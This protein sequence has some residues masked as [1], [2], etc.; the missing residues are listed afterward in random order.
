MVTNS[1]LATDICF[2][3][4]KK[5]MKIKGIISDMDGVIYRGNKLIPEAKNFIECLHKNQLPFFFLTNNSEL[6]ALDLKLKMQA[7]GIE[8][9]TENNF[10]T[11]AMA[12]A[13]FLKNQ[14]PGSK[15]FVIGKGGLINELY[16]A[17]FSLTEHNP[18]YV[19]VGKTNDFNFTMLKKAV[20]LINQ[21][22]KFI[23]T[24]PDV[25]DPIENGVEPACGSILAAIEKAANKAPYIIGKPNALIMTIAT[26]KLNLH[27]EEILMVGDRMDTDIV[28]GLEA[29]MKT[30]LVL[31]GVSQRETLNEFPFQPDFV[32]NNVGEIQTIFNF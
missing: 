17:G 26:Q 6:T 13:I 16:N 28:A 24:N 27:S 23:G 2:S 11:S 4:T 18:D 20:N 10:I 3:Y 21:G 31:T 14:K 5:I 30:C 22:A 8:G 25:I 7:L 12:T 15:I 1:S 32:L 29:G 19:V 9:I